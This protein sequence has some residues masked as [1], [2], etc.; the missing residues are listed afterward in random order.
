MRKL[1][2]AVLLLGMSCSVEL[3]PSEVGGQDGGTPPV[4]MVTPVEPGPAL[5]ATVRSGDDMKPMPSRLLIKAVA[6][7]RRPDF[8]SDGFSTVELSAGLLADPEGVLLVTGQA[9]VPLPVGTYQ[10]RAVQGPEHEL[11]ER[12]V[13]ITA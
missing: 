10:V 5:L 8:K 6:P 4:Q 9:R 1:G 2:P 13:Q 7:T 12:T 3:P 11:V